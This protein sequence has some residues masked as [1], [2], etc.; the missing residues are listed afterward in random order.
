MKK[1]YLLIA[2]PAV[3]LSQGCEDIINALVEKNELEVIASGVCNSDENTYKFNNSYLEEVHVS[4]TGFSNADGTHYF[5]RVIIF[6]GGY[7][8]VTFSG[9]EEINGYHDDTYWASSSSVEIYA[10]LCQDPDPFYYENCR[11][12]LTD[13]SV[14]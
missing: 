9:D 8:L 1:L 13:I 7:E 2:F 3:F 10:E 11:I 5:P 14:Y 6:C 12:K 4:F